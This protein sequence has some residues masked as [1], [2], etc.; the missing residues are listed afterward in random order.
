MARSKKKATITIPGMKGVE[1][2]RS[3]V[4]E[5][6]YCVEVEE[7]TL[8][9]GQNGDY[10]KWVLPITG[11]E[12]EGSKLFYN[13]SLT[14]QSLWNLRGVMEALGIDPPDEETDMD[15]EE[16]VGASMMVMV[17]HEDYNGKPQ[18]RIVDYWP[19]DEKKSSKDEDKPSKNKKSSDDEEEDDKP[20]KKSRRSRDEEDEDEKPSRKR[21]K[22][23]ND[24]DDKPAR[25]KKNSKKKQLISEDEVSSMDEESLADLIEEHK[26]DIDLDDFSTMRKKRAAVVEMLADA[27]LLAD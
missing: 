2:K 1:G 18:A 7:L 12:H 20:A 25:G 3:A 8:E 5:G 4:P 13:T 6:E 22:R 9:E 17:E 19:A 23:D 26:L 15:L 21:N 11:G 27:E 24:E 16:F 10:L 14:P